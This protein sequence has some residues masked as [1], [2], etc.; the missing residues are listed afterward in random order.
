MT[1]RIQHR[2]SLVAGA[3]LPNLPML[4]GELALNLPDLQLF[5]TTAGTP[6]ALLGVRAFA[7]TAK[8]AAKDVM[9]MTGNLYAA[10]VA[11]GPKAFSAADWD[12]LTGGGGVVLNPVL[13]PDGAV[14]APSISFASDTNTGVFLAAPDVLALAVAGVEVARLTSALV[15]LNKPLSVTGALSTT[16]SATLGGGLVLSGDI[17][18]ANDKKVYWGDGTAFVQG[19]GTTDVLTVGGLAAQF[20][21]AP[22]GALGVRDGGAYGGT[23]PTALR[24]AVVVESNGHTGLSFLTPDGSS[25]GINFGDASL[26]TAGFVAYDHPTDTMSLG[27][28]AVTKLLLD[29]NFVRATVPWYAANDT[30]AAPGYAWVGTPTMGMFRAAAGIIGW[31]TGGVEKMRLTASTDAQLLAGLTTALNGNAGRG[32]VEVNGTSDSVLSMCAVGA[33]VGYLQ[34]QAA[35]LTLG[36][37]V[38]VPLRFYVNNAEAGRFTATGLEFL[39]GTPSTV[40]AAAG[41]GLVEINGTTT[42]YLGLDTGN[43]TRVALLTSTAL[44]TLTTAVGT[45]L[46]IGTE[47][48]A[49]I[50]IDSNQVA[51]YA[52]LEIGWRD[53]PALAANAAMTAAARGK[54]IPVSA[55]YTIPTG[56][57][58][59]STICLV[60]TTAAAIT[61]TGFA[62]LHLAGTALTGNRTLAPW[63][64]CTIWFQSTTVAFITGSV[65]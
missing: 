30:A 56:L 39:V 14:G 46:A 57:P 16:G 10:K 34:A 21:G 64:F 42:A 50:A 63:G 20:F 54:V 11:V 33:K 23:G 17:A 22:Y 27:V 25:S 40:N 5:T 6:A 58:A 7:A 41:R 13:F 61:L 32:L 51:T 65:S 4:A 36:T 31:A 44:A 38:A 43:T 12:L 47:S 45:T 2:R 59:N 1:S 26:N 49:C 8:Y 24:D 55:A 3:A 18:L 37:Q 48:A 35:A 19:N 28:T 53:I 9:A 52:A 15:T 62:G 29:V 60:N